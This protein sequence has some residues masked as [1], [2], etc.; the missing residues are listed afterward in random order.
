MIKHGRLKRAALLAAPLLA[1][2][3][4]AHPAMAA[5]PAPASA[6]E[7]SVHV[8]I[9]YHKLENGLK[10]VISPDHS[11]PTTTIGVYYGIGFR[12]EPKN[13]TGFA[14]LFE[15]M[16]FQGSENLG[17]AEFIGLVN[18]NGGV[19]NGS[20]RFDFTNYY[21]V[22]PSNTT[23]T[24]LWAEADRMKGLDIT[25]AN[26]TNQQGV[27]KNEVKVNVLNQPYGGFPWLDLPQ[28]AN[29]NWYNAHNFYG[30]L[31][32][33]DAATLEDVQKFFDQYYAPNNAVL[34]VAGDVDPTQVMDWAKQY[35]GP[36]PA[37]AAIPRP[38]ISEPRQT[39]QKRI[40]KVDPLAPQPAL[41]WAYHVPPKGTPEAAAF[42]LID[43]LLIQGD[44]SR[45]NR[46]L[47]NQKGYSDS[48]DGGINWPLG[49]AYDYNGPMLWS[50]MLVH[51]GDVTDDQILSDIDGIVKDL[52]ANLVSPDELERAKTKALSRLYDTIGNGNRVGLV[53]MLATFALFDD[54]PNRV[55][56]LEKEIEAVTPEMI[57]KTAREYL[58]PTNRSIIDLKPGKAAAQDG[59]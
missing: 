13:R 15:H 56:R 42:R 4:A 25:Q 16:M 55:N 6:P 37:A 24:F 23:E 10:V 38:D 57:R 19:L 1:F 21:E 40:E 14:H 58:R 22:V 27:V 39:E 28:L 31:K 9:A 7:A 47:V 18:K 45:F 35:F 48:V 11:V 5:D 26:L 20:T 53:N 41:A 54:D 46:V 30:D 49:D 44:D 17:K 33:I 50:G 2:A 8:P 43:L 51:S 29:T 34:V 12:L 59:Q 52:Q 36:I 3:T 32:E